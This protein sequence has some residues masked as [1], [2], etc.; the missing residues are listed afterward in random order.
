MNWWIGELV[1]CL[2]RATAR[3]LI[4]A[5]SPIHEIT[6]S[7]I[8]LDDNRQPAP[9]EQAKFTVD[10][11]H[12]RQPRTALFLHPGLKLA[13]KRT[14]RGD[15]TPPVTVQLGPWASVRGRAV[16]ADGQ[17]IAKMKLGFYPGY[18]V[19]IDVNGEHVVTLKHLEIK[20]S[21][22]ELVSQGMTVRQIRLD[23][24]FLALRHDAGGWNVANLIKRQQQEANRQGP[25][26][27]ITLPDV[28]IAGGRATVDDSAPSPSY[29]IPRRID[30]MNVNA[31][32]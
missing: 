26:K 21:I 3:A 10:N 14:L 27:P 31:A 19:A 6:N 20:Y 8:A 16:D 22:A 2:A 15:E 23:E 25:G 30:G 12:P 7:P 18:D 32:S 4:D 11:V 17:P 13:G 9:L 29:R 28:E 5:N 24:P 1:N